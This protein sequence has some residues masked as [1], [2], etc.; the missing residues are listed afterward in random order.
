MTNTHT[1]TSQDGQK[2]EIDFP[3][4]RGGQA[5]FV[6]AGHK[7]G[8]VLLNNIIADIQTV[9]GLPAVPVETSLWKQGLNIKD[10]PQELYDLL[11][12]DGL[13]YMSFRDLQKLPQLASFQHGKRIFMIRDPRDVAVSYFFSMSQSHT[14]PKEG[15]AREG[16]I[17]M[18]ET[19]SGFDIDQFIQKGMA[20]AVLRNIESFAHFLNTE[21]T[22]FYKYEDIIF[23]K[24]SWVAQIASDLEVEIPQNDIERIAKKH[25]IRPSKEDPSA[26]IRSVTP[27]GYTAKIKPET[28]AYIQ[29]NFPKFFS[30]YGYEK[31]PV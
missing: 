26:H 10:W 11:E 13:V 20:N 27:G 30:E 19:A 17:K 25:D 7:T 3:E 9:T 12:Q 8:S 23:D 5:T 14:L 31:D 1:I 28:I 2:F 4:P 21:N 22:V 18:R 6:V 29:Q 16:L 15:D 24:E